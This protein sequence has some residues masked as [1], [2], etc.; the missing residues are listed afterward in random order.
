MTILT[1]AQGH[2][3]D[4]MIEK[5]IQYDWSIYET[6]S[7]IKKFLN[8]TI[9]FRTLVRRANRVFNYEFFEGIAELTDQQILGFEILQAYKNG[10]SRR[11]ISNKFNIDYTCGNTLLRKAKEMERKHENKTA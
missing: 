6:K 11:E 9:D 7:M 2:K 8:I 1:V 3:V 10:L 5:A 4:D